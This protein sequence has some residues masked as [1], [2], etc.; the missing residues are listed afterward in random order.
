MKI[1]QVR[2]Y[3]IIDAISDVSIMYKA[4]SSVFEVHF[5]IHSDH[6]GKLSSTGSALKSIYGNE[7]V[8]NDIGQAYAYVRNLGWKQLVTVCTVD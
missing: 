3:V 1:T 4:S 2:R 7:R 5:F 8:W 6:V